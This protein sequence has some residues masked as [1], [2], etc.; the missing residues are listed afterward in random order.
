M[1]GVYEIE[2][3]IPHVFLVCI[4][5][6]AEKNAKGLNQTSRYMLVASQQQRLK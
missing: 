3:W 4:E 2:L 5:K 1:L 6:Y